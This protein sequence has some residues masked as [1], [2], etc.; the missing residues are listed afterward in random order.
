MPEPS[1]AGNESESSLHDEA[2]KEHSSDDSS[3]VKDEDSYSGDLLSGIGSGDDSGEP[4]ESSHA[5]DESETLLAE[6]N[7]PES[8][9]GEKVSEQPGVEKSGESEET[10]ES[11]IEKGIVHP[12]E[13]AG[14]GKVFVMSDAPEAFADL[15]EEKKKEEELPELH[16]ILR[17]I[18]LRVP[19]DGVFMRFVSSSDPEMTDYLEKVIRSS[20]E[21][22]R[23]DG[24]DKMFSIYDCSLSVLI[25]AAKVND[26]LRKEELLNNAGA[27]MYSKHKKEW[28]ALVLSIDSDFHISDA[29]EKVIT[30]SSFSPS[31]WKICTIIGEQLIAR[32]R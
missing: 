31:N 15:R 27:V 13:L 20:W 32:G 12:V 5:E 4:E 22:Q 19:R 28:N 7:S 25:A 9:D 14:G 3:S 29:Y 16:G 23:S 18:A 26:D 24:K 10:A 1:S 2:E 6:D 8:A 17:E 11:L 30:P 21:R